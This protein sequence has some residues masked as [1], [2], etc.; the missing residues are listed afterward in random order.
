M[1]DAFWAFLGNESNQKTLAWLGG[2]LVT[3]AGGAWAVIQLVWSSKKVDHGKPPDQPKPPATNNVLADHG[4]FA[5]S[6]NISMS[7]S[8]ATRTGINGP[9]LIA[10]VLAAAGTVL[11]A[12]ALTGQRLTADNCGTVVG[13]DIKGGSIR[14][15]CGSRQ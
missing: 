1:I 3:V 10:L 8:T 5:V 4:G 11:L 12:G 2:G 9:S 15:E 14:T 6:G 13:G 7:H